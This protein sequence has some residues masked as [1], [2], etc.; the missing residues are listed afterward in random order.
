VLDK[1]MHRR[2]L[3]AWVQQSRVA[4]EKCIREERT[5]ALRRDQELDAAY[6]TLPDEDDA[7]SQDLDDF[8][9]VQKEVRVISRDTSSQGFND[10]D[11]DVGKE[12]CV[13]YKNA[14]YPAT[15]KKCQAKAGRPG[16]LVHLHCMKAK[17]VR[18]IPLEDIIFSTDDIE[19]SNG[20]GGAT[21]STNF[22]HQSGRNKREKYCEGG[23][24]AGLQSRIGEKYQVSSCHIPPSS[25]WV[26]G[27]GDGDFVPATVE[28]LLSATME[29]EPLS[30]IEQ[31]A[32]CDAIRKYG[33][34][35]TE[36]ARAVGT[37][38]N[39]CLVHYYS[40]FKTGENRNVYLQEKKCWRSRALVNYKG[41]SVLATVLKRREFAGKPG[42][43]VHFDGS[44]RKDLRWIPQHDIITSIDGD[45]ESEDEVDSS[46]IFDDNNTPHISVSF[47]GEQFSI[48]VES[49]SKTLL[50][51][52]EVIS[53]EKNLELLPKDEYYFYLLDGIISK[54][55]EKRYL[56]EDIVKH[57]IPVALIFKSDLEEK[58]DNEFKTSTVR[59]DHQKLTHAS[60]LDRKWDE[61]LEQLKTFK[62]EY[63]HIDVAKVFKDVKHPLRKFINTIRKSHN[64][65]QTGRNKSSKVLT[66]QRLLELERIGF[67]FQT[68]LSWEYR[69]QELRKHFEEHG[70]FEVPSEDHA[71]SL[72]ANKQ[73]YYYRQ[74]IKYGEKNCLSK[75]RIEL[76][77][78]IGFDWRFDTQD[79]ND[80]EMINQGMMCLDT[81]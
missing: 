28:N 1:L 26:R 66:D 33:K 78:S 36:I 43:F 3:L 72:W 69:F 79:G 60:Q 15:I 47:K 6:T 76:L 40:T 25:S 22:C 61:D 30:M 56:I 37:S 14:H 42:L 34:H 53:E 32:F 46:S 4:V 50:D 20:D 51:L 9:D 71:A 18:W 57:N 65:L 52:R 29:G 7:S 44:D 58:S 16:Y 59:A 54:K 11:I 41:A 67:I 12:V 39:R 64:L 81:A 19:E 38:V 68:Y 73:R 23:F 10:V 62:E 49:T 21:E 35:F 45:V 8:N 77:D 13:E 48:N 17:S 27:D 63:G 80:V 74:T 70:N 31:A 24:T 55:Q 5:L 2:N 75:S